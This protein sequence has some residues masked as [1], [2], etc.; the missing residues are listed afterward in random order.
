[1]HYSYKRV[2]V[3]LLVIVSASC[4]SDSGNQSEKAK[5]EIIQT[6]KDFEKMAAEK[7]I[8]AAFWYYADSNAVIRGN[9]D[10]LVQGKDGIKNFFQPNDSKRLL[11]NG[12][13]ILQTLLPVANWAIPMANIPGFRKTVQAK[14]V[15]TRAFFIRSGKNKKTVPGDLSGINRSIF[16]LYCFP[17]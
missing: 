17:Q 16:L 1:M 12:R 15:K 2:P 8:A 10:S 3:L 13:Q 6:E 9:N 11:L 7:G 14:P 4:H 5:K